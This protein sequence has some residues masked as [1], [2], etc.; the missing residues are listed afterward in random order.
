MSTLLFQKYH[1]STQE[2]NTITYLIRQET[3]WEMWKKRSRKH[4]ESFFPARDCW[5]ATRGWLG[6]PS[7]RLLMSSATQVFWVSCSLLHPATPHYWHDA[8]GCWAFSLST[9]FSSTKGSFLIKAVKDSLARFPSL[10]TV[11]QPYIW[12]NWYWSLE[13]IFLSSKEAKCYVNFERS[14]RRVCLNYKVQWQE[15]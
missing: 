5:P 10:L 8:S 4:R 9:C 15:P 12:V 1:S 14:L 3:T 7:S 2:T 6:L 11:E 13:L